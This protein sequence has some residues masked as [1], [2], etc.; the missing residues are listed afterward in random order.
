MGQ[1][2]NIIDAI[3]LA[4]EYAQEYI[5]TSEHKRK[6]HS[7]SLMKNYEGNTSA[8][9]NTVAGVSASFSTVARS[10]KTFWINN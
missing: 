10:Q 5:N 2:E 3:S 4:I 8:P 6:E 9:E 7:I 1:K